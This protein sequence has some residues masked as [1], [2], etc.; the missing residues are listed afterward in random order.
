MNQSPYNTT[1]TDTTWTIYQEPKRESV[2]NDLLN[3][4]M[5]NE[6]KE[7]ELKIKLIEL[8]L[9]HHNESADQKRILSDVEALWAFVEKTN[10]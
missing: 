7:K 3:K 6:L 10:N 4:H 1:T 9:N 5:S 2:V 8:V